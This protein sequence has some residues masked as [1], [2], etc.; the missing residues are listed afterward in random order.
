VE[1]FSSL[2]WAPWRNGNTA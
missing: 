2:V 1:I